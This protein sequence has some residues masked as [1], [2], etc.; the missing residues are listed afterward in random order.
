QEAVILYALSNGFLDD[1]P[2]NKLEDF[3]TQFQQYM[4]ASHADV[5]E[6]ITNEKK[7]SPETEEKLKQAIDEFKKSTQFE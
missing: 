5:A 1:V 3:Q 6:A 4:E 7:I 2:V